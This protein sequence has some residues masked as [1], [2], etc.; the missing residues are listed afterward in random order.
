M[1]GEENCREGSLLDGDEPAW[2]EI[3]KA[4]IK[5]KH[6][7]DYTFKTAS[8]CETTLLA[9]AGKMEEYEMKV[10]LEDDSD[11]DDVLDKESAPSEVDDSSGKEE[12]ETDD[13]LK[14]YYEWLVEV[15]GG[16]RDEKSAKQYQTQ[17]K[18]VIRKLKELSQ[19]DEHKNLSGSELLT[20]EGQ[21]G[22]TLLKKWL[23]Y[24]VKKYQPGTVRS[25]LMSIRL[26]YKY[27]S[28]D[29]KTPSQDILTSRRDLMT[30][31]SSAQKKK[32]LRRRLNKKDADYKKILSGKNLH[33]VCHGN[34]RV[35]AIKQLGKT[36]ATTNDGQHSF[37]VNDKSY[38]EARDYLTT[39]LTID[40][41]GRSGIA[42]NLTLEEF[43]DG[44]F[45]E[46]D[47]EDE[48]RYRVF[49]KEHKTAI[50][51][52]AAIIWIYSDLYKLIEMYIKTLR[53]QVTHSNPLVPNVF[54]SSTGMPLTSS[55]V[56]TAIWRTFQRENIQVKGR[57]SAT[58]I[59]KSLA[60]GVHK[61]LPQDKLKLA[62]LA[63]HKS[64]TQGKY[65]VVHDKIRDADLGRRAVKKLIS[66]KTNDHDVEDSGVNITHVEWTVQEEEWLAN[67]FSAEINTGGITDEV[68]RDKHGATN[69]LQNHT[70]K[71]VVQKLKAM[72]EKHMETVALPQE[73]E[74]SHDKALRYL[75]HASSVSASTEPPTSEARTWSK[76]S[77]EQTEYLVRINKDMVKSNTIKRELVW[78]R[79]KNDKTALQLGL[80]VQDEESEARQKQRLADKLRQEVRRL[81]AKKKRS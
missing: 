2:K 61:H 12:L 41:S 70:F 10:I 67:M 74:N 7:K 59:R 8:E 75:E 26:F 51:Y 11:S 71:A 50:I 17:V 79:L 20:L 80:I 48:A 72:R 27:L 34:Q 54:V 55:Q 63:Q 60:T 44:V 42:S 77:N 43:E 6:Q 15:D 65:Y 36:C 18:S 73:E 4:F 29:C 19:K 40:N 35:Q 23:T 5:D 22:V 16:Y 45:Y 57:V 30:S 69:I 25:Y 62:A 39:R 37:L 46:G 13:M 49:V 31:W 56:S 68:V 21:E 58:T 33:Q 53:K 52:W 28:Q 1:I 24:T 32:S 38:C 76:F 78:Q 3:V 9:E 81:K 66:M 64:E 47:E 14:Q